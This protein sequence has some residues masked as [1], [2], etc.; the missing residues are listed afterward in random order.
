[1]FGIPSS[2]RRHRS[3]PQESTDSAQKVSSGTSYRPSQRTEVSYETKDG[4]IASE[5]QVIAL[6]QHTNPNE[7]SV[8][9]ADQGAT[10]KKIGS[11]KL[12]RKNVRRS[13]NYSHATSRTKDSAIIILRLR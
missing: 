5:T 12:G 11:N 10:S 2:S 4:A 1:M 13:L 3:V 9:R 7:G 8:R 6:L